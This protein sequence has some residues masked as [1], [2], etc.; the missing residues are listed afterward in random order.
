MA[1]FREMFATHREAAEETI[2]ELVRRVVD[3]DTIPADV[4][5]KAAQAAG[6]TAD[7]V[8][9]MAERMRNRDHL[10]RVAAGLDAAAAEISKLTDAIAKHDAVLTEAERRHHAATVPLRVLLAEAEARHAEAQRADAALLE[11]RHMEPSIRDRLRTAQAE[12]HAASTAVSALTAEQHEQTRRGETAGH[13]LVAAGHDP[14]KLE[15]MWRDE[16]TR[17]LLSNNTERVFLD[18]LRGHR[19]AKEAAE[20]L[21]DARAALEAA[22]RTVEEIQLEARSS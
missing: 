22:K 6:M 3:G 13:E 16:S 10:R 12:Y 8:D 19:R 21:P 20:K 7:D 2:V 1:T 9:A 17:H 18:W 4:L 14:A 11:P 5:C 15:R